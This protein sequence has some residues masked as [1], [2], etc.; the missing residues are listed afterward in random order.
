MCFLSPPIIMGAVPEDGADA[1]AYGGADTDA[2]G[3]AD[4]DAYGGADADAYGGAD[5]DAVC[6]VL[7]GVW[8]VSIACWMSACPD[9]MV[10]K[11]VIIILDVNSL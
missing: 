2:Y 6:L 11:L 8:T 4:A 1:D 3:G 10:V 9:A 7:D 5:A